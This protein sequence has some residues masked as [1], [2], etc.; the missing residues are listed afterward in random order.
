MRRAQGG[1]A[2]CTKKAECEACGEEY[3]ELGAHTEAAI[4]AVAPTCTEIGYTAGVE[5][6]DCGE[7]VEAT[8]EVVA[9]DHDYSEE[10]RTIDATCTEG[11]YVV[12]GCSRCDSENVV[13]FGES[14]GHEYVMDDT[15]T[16]G[17]TYNVT[18]SDGEDNII[19][20]FFGKGETYYIDLYKY[21][22]VASVFITASSYATVRI[23]SLAK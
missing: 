13:L 4:E 14:N 10:E 20:N 2:A 7:I 5:C 23:C 17:V 18:I 6:A 19:M 21:E 22:G 16:E 3:G 8:E 12:Y 9:L 11:A 1:T 15:A